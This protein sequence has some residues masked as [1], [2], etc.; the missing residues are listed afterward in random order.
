MARFKPNLSKIE[1]TEDANI[2][3]REIGIIE[4]ELEAIDADAQKRIGD[5]KAD[6]AKRG[7]P[8]RSRII[9]LSGQLGAFAEYNK[10]ELFK[11][12]KSME[13]TFGVFGYRKTTS[14]HIK[15]S[16]VD[17]LRKLNLDRFVRVKEEPDKEAMAVLDDDQLAMVDAVRKSKDDFFCEA[18]REEINKDLLRASA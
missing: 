13:L 5:I 9:E 7:E 18:N 3:L 1:N 15:K 16:T 8:L 14:I 4:R 17:L 11:D 10:A 12:R 6:A 2:A